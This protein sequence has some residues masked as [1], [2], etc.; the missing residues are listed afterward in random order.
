MSERPSSSTTPAPATEDS[1][2]GASGADARPQGAAPP[3][4]DTQSES[5]PGGP[6]RPAAAPP[7]ADRLEVAA[8]IQDDAWTAELPTADD[9]AERACTA[10]WADLPASARPHAPAGAEVSV[11][12]ADD[13]TVQALN[14]EYRGHDTPTNV[15]SFANLEDARAPGPLDGEPLLLGDIVLAR[16]TVL[17]EARAQTKAPGDHLSHLCVHG[18]LHLLGY[19]HMAEAEA[20]TMEALERRTLARLGIADPYAERHVDAGVDA[21]PADALAGG[22]R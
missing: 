3:G 18:L 15:L 16:E 2:P 20:E 22:R 14:R 7:D 10:A 13:A 11:V 19:D 12:L 9:T 21:L 17:A 4:A 6:P 1:S 8:L 5:R